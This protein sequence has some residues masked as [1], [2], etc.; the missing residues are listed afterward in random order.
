MHL[1]GFDLFL[2]AA[3]FLLQFILITVL[4]VRRRAR[5]FPVFTLFVGLTLAETA[6]LYL[7]F[8]DLS[9]SAYYYAYWAF[10]FA[11]MAVQLAL[12]YEIA[13]KVFAPLGEWAPDVRSSF[14]RLIGASILA[15]LILSLLVKPAQRTPFEMLVLRGSFFS[16]V[17]MTELCAGL[18][19]LSATAGL[20]WKTHVARI[21]Q[22]IG[23][24][25]FVGV[26][27]D[28]AVSWFGWDNQASTIHALSQF[29][30][31]VYVSSVFCWTI[32]LWRNAPDRRKLSGTMRMQVFNLQRL[33]E[34][35]LGR[36]R[37]WRKV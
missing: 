12:L 37:G 35:D 8:R 11:D 16:S 29:R 7:V 21:A 15:A 6:I 3:G 20:P 19:V 9:R 22:G 10:A 23:V 4:I 31:A 30:I 13:R 1:S 34:Y 2:W 32:L 24:Y 28:T 36:I 5:S 14:I 25:S 17:L 26:I 27:V 18:V 33:V